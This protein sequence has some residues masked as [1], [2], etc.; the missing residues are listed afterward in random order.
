[1]QSAAGSA[2]RSPPAQLRVYQITA[3]IQPMHSHT[4]LFAL[5]HAAFRLSQEP[6]LPVC[7]LR[8]TITTL[9]TNSP[10]PVATRNGPMLNIAG[11]PPISSRIQ[12]HKVDFEGR[13]AVQTTF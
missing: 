9:A 11:K 4:V 10:T 7:R 8:G 13:E 5:K 2:Y 6:S 3:T 1:M 12:K